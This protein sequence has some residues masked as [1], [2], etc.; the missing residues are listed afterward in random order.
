M[1]AHASSFWRR[2]CP[3]VR[4]GVGMRG[5]GGGAGT[6]PLRLLAVSAAAPAVGG[7]GGARVCLPLQ[8]PSLGTSPTAVKAPASSLSLGPHRSSCVFLELRATPIFTSTGIAPVED[9]HVGLALHAVGGAVQA[10]AERKRY[11]QHGD[12]QGRVAVG[13]PLRAS[14]AALVLACHLA[15]VRTWSHLYE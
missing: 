12:L 14:G 10:P 6:H 11:D 5:D 7:R 13:R 9:L 1:P 3:R 8:A 4:R 15:R 2:A